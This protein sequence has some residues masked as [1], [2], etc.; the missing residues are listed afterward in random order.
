M[1]LPRKGATANNNMYNIIILNRPQLP[2]KND[3]LLNF[4]IYSVPYLVYNNKD[5]FIVNNI[6][7]D[8]GTF[9]TRIFTNNYLFQFP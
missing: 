2:V 9:Y 1:V 3:I 7:L 8:Y 4:I 6:I 5:R